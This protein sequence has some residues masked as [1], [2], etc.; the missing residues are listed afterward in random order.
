MT[1]IPTVQGTLA[2]DLVPRLDPPP[3][4]EAPAGTRRPQE[5]DA[6]VVPIDRQ[7]R[8]ELESWTWRYAQSVVEVVAGDRPVSQLLRWTTPPVYADLARRA[9]LVARAGGHLPGQG[10]PRR[11]AARAQV[12]GV[13]TSFVGRDAAETSIHVRH[14]ERSRAIA[15]RFELVGGR[16]QC[17]ALEFA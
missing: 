5:A 15:A 17:C 6:D 12:L 13:R 14:G 4:P 9:H 7:R 11:A 8:R 2:L 16:W 10:R 3:A 1:D